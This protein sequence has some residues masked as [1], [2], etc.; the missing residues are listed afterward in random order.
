MLDDILKNGFDLFGILP[1]SYAGLGLGSLSRDEMSP[2]SDLE[3]AL[4]IG[5]SSP[6][7]V[8]YF[9]QMVGWLELQVIHLGETP[10]NILKMD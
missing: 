2:Y 9:R 10:I 8:D 5:D 1:C 7:I 3:F 4:L 6:D